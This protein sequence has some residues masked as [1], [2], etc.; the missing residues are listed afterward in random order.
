LSDR[1]KEQPVTEQ[2]PGL[3]SFWLTPTDI[4]GF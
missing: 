3:V 1:K 2:S 4:K